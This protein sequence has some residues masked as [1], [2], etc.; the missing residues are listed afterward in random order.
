[1]GQPENSCSWPAGA[2]LASCSVRSCMQSGCMLSVAAGGFMCMMADRLSIQVLQGCCACILTRLTASLVQRLCTAL[3]SVACC[4]RH[5]DAAC[6]PDAATFLLD[7]MM[8]RP[9]GLHAQC[10]VPGLWAEGCGLAPCRQISVRCW[11]SSTRTVSACLGLLVRLL[12]EN[13]PQI[14]MGPPMQWFGVLVHVIIC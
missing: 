3:N 8:A 2:A 13:L 14:G 5:P 12:G 10:S 9:S 4:T 7:C 1:M 6:Q 11:R